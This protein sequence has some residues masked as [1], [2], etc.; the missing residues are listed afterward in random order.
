MRATMVPHVFA[1]R[2][3]PGESKTL[4]AWRRRPEHL[5]VAGAGGGLAI[6][7]LSQSLASD[8][9][10]RI[11]LRMPGRGGAPAAPGVSDWGLLLLPQQEILISSQTRETAHLRR[12]L[13]ASP[14]AAANP[15]GGRH[16]RG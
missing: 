12:C 11:Q 1:R 13:L 2:P 6:G 15:D 16:A 9:S 4:L 7:R 14:L 8:F 3:Q 5:R 10:N